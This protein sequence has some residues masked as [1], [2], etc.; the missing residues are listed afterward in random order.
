MQIGFAGTPSFAATILKTLIASPHDLVSVFTQP[1]RSAGRGQKRRRSPVQLVSDAHHIETHTPTRLKDQHEHFASLDMLVVAAY[2]LILP[3]AVLDAPRFGCINVHASLLPRWRGASPI[4]HAIL[5]GDR[6]TG[7][8]IM[9][10]TRGLDQGPVYRQAEIALS[11]HC[12]LTSLTDALAQLGAKEIVAFLDDAASNA[13]S[14]PLPQD[15]NLVTYAPLLEKNAAR[16]NWQASATSIERQVRAFNGRGMAFTS[17]SGGS[18]PVRIRILE[19]EVAEEPGKPGQLIETPQG[20]AVACGDGS[21]LVRQ[22]QLNMGKGKPLL[23]R[24]AV[25]GYP[26]ILCAGNVLGTTE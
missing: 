5:E 25:N 23:I 1:A 22:V 4:E 17:Y 8:S 16:I 6:K 26:S 15:E 19:A 9:Q 12:N 14:Q 2:G 10:M 3:Q 24:D 13:H 21:L 7:I 20:L 18:N 11:N